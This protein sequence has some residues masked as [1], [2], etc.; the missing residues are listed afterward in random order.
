[1]PGIQSLVQWSQPYL[2]P[3]IDRMGFKAH[4]GC[5]SELSHRLW[6]STAVSVSF[7]VYLFHVL[8]RVHE[9][10]GWFIYTQAAACLSSR[11]VTNPITCLLKSSVV[12]S[13]FLDESSPCSL[14]WPG[15]P[16]V[17]QDCLK[18]RIPRLGSSSVRIADRCYCIKLS[19]ICLNVHFRVRNQEI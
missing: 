13:F 12:I 19:I 6:D 15:T 5:G 1:M 8:R 14:G 10:P 4:R 17:A 3:S 11:I 7:Q 16:C 9:I 18:H 2:L